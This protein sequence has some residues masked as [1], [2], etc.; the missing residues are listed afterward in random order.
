MC[1]LVYLFKSNVG[2]EKYAY[3]KYIY[4]EFPQNE[5][6]L[7]TSIILKKKRRNRLLPTFR[8]PSC[9]LKEEV[10]VVEGCY[11]D[12]NVWTGSW[13]K[14]GILADEDE[15]WKKDITEVSK[16]TVPPKRVAGMTTSRSV[17]LSRAQRVCKLSSSNLVSGQLPEGFNASIV[18][19]LV[20]RRKI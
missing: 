9:Y 2:T 15:T 7:V 1:G 18:F 16:W 5:D 17:Q 10:G 3:I 13:G 12:G 14:A 4:G 6:I 20:E 11:E 8:S 19:C